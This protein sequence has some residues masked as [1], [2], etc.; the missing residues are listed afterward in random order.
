MR[1]GDKG[2]EGERRRR[3]RTERHAHSILSHSSL[4]TKQILSLNPC[5]PSAPHSGCLLV[6]SAHVAMRAAI[7][8]DEGSERRQC[9]LLA[10]CR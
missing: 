3:L 7:E 10:L 2:T 8:L 4:H 1:S 5:A 6:Q 9:K